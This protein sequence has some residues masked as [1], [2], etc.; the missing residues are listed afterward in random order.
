M[1]TTIVRGHFLGLL[2]QRQLSKGESEN[3]FVAGIL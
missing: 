2:G 3:L 1:E